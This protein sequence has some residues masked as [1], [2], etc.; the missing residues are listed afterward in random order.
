MN[1]LRN[2]ICFS[3]GAIGCLIQGPAQSVGSSS[4]IEKRAAALH[5]D[6]FPSLSKTLTF[7]K[8]SRPEASFLPA[9]GTSADC[10]ESTLPPS[11]MSPLPASK[12]SGLLATTTW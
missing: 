1:V 11:Q 9:K 6:G 7:Q 2:Q 8:Q 5:A 12:R 4:P 3:T 10:E